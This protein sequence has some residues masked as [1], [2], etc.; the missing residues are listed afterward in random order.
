MGLTSYFGGGIS[1]LIEQY[2]KKKEDEEKDKPIGKIGLTYDPDKPVG[3]VGAIEVAPVP[4][5]E[6]PK[7]SDLSPEF[8]DTKSRIDYYREKITWLE[9]IAEE[10]GGLG[11]SGYDAYRY[12][13][14]K[15]NENVNLYNKENPMEIQ[16]PKKPQQFEQ[17]GVKQRQRGIGELPRT[18]IESDDLPKTVRFIDD[19][20]AGAPKGIS[21]GVSGFAE[22]FSN[23]IVEIGEREQIL[24]DPEEYEPTG[25]TKD[26]ADFIK[27]LLIA[28]Y[29]GDRF[30]KIR[31]EVATFTTKQGQKLVQE[32]QEWG[33]QFLPKADASEVE[34]FTADLFAGGTSLV[35]AIGVAVVTK[36][37]KAA[38]MV[39]GLSARGGT[40]GAAREADVD[41]LKA[42]ALGG[43]HQLT[44][45]VTEFIGL[46]FILTKMPVGKLLSI[47]MKGIGEGFQE[48][49]QGWFGNL[50]EK[51]G[52]NIAKDT[53]EGLN[54]ET[55]IGFLLGGGASLVV[56]NISEE[57]GI[58]REDIQTE[59]EATYQHI[60]D[61]TKDISFQDVV[62]S[63]ED[64]QMDIE[65]TSTDRFED[66]LDQPTEE[67]LDSIDETEFEDIP[68]QYE[69]E[70]RADIERPKIITLYKQEI[71]ESKAKIKTTEE[72]LKVAPK[73]LKRGYENDLI[74][75]HS[76]ITALE[77]RIADKETRALA[78][79]TISG[80]AIEA[81]MAEGEQTDLTVTDVGTLTVTDEELGIT[82]TGEKLPAIPPREMKEYEPIH[83]PNVHAVLGEELKFREPT[84]TKWYTPKLELMRNLGLE[85]ILGN[86]PEAR[87][88]MD[89]KIT[90]INHEINEV[91]KKLYKGAGK[92]ERFKAWLTNKPIKKVA[93]MRDLL[94]EYEKA[95]EYLSPSE[96]EI[97]NNVRDLT[98]NLLNIT[99][100]FRRAAGLTEIPKLEAYIPHFLDEV[101][102]AAADGKYPY[103]AD[104]YRWTGKKF[105]RGKN[106]TSRRRTVSK[107]TD[108]LNETFDKDLGKLLKAMVKYDLRDVFLALPY[109]QVRA[110][111]NALKGQIPKDTLQE[112]EEYMQ[113]DIFDSMTN[114]DKSINRFLIPGTNFLNVLLKPFGRVITDPVRLLSGAYRQGLMGGAIAGKPRIVIRNLFQRLLTMDLVPAGDFIKAQFSAPQDVM[115]KI[116][117]TT[118]YKSSVA[119]FED[120]PPLMKPVQIGM[121]PFQKSHAGLKFISNIDV[122]MRAGYNYG[123]RMIEWTNSD[124]GQKYIKD[125]AKKRGIKEGTKEYNEL[126]W[127]EGD[128]I[129]EA[130]EIGSRSQW[131]YHSTDMP[132]VFRGHGARA[133]WSLQSWW[134]NYFGKHVS[135]MSKRT[136]KGKTGRG[137]VIR[138]SDRSLSVR[139]MIAIFAMM[140]ALK[141][142]TGI[143]MIRYTIFPLPE[144]GKLPHGGQLLIDTYK[145][146]QGSV[147]EK[148]QAI[149]EVGK[150]LQLL[151]PFSGA[152]KRYKDW[153]TGEISTKKMFFYMEYDNAWKQIWINVTPTKSQGVKPMGKIGGRNK[154]GKPKGKIG[155]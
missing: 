56:D 59:V 137:R 7:S 19:I 64:Y 15:F 86:L 130:I 57:H 55:L 68:A 84:I 5:V 145:I 148:K 72:K 34:K 63:S 80:E 110:E 82:E 144:M 24:A 35:G 75:E 142:Y 138:K 93:N 27:K 44:E 127:R 126:F 45:T 6:T 51:Y 42:G 119:T 125:Y 146:F 140:A 65:P 124:K 129:K 2:K 10:K 13:I 23:L 33:R 147:E 43:V 74:Y 106:P 78:P 30:K 79:D 90:T 38:A 112:L 18:Q 85:E 9:G 139:G 107:I 100:K 14:E 94:N 46:E 111:I 60:N 3:K 70:M 132:R 36:N 128:Q 153:F 53:N 131:F 16:E 4:T 58:D 120:L 109:A 62:D 69:E 47:P 26:E 95:P 71:E 96:R 116:R 118:F 76:R 104:V 105:S 17:T 54:R 37:P 89:L 154:I 121:I 99:N 52:W 87:Q 77:E 102:K 98:T 12:A 73:A 67:I 49:T 114:L 66:Y 1:T 48:R 97:F 31:G 81:T 61:M 50:V 123:Q 32:A 29:G 21:M 117:E 133:F 115:D 20:F 40:Y 25:K 101:A 88:L 11:G 150:G 143:D 155:E 8:T 39:F 122:A 28:K 149:K 108:L 151:I 83:I 41:P 22:S 141:K 91:M 152:Y 103:V 92:G 136:F 135:E 134:M 113:Y